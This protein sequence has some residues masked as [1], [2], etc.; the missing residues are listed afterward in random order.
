MYKIIGSSKIKI[1]TAISFLLSL[2]IKIAG[3]VKKDMHKILNAYVPINDVT[4]IIS[5]LLEKLYAIRFH[6]NPVKTVPLKNSITPNKRENKNK[7][8]AGFLIL[9]KKKQY[10]AKP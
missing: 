3:L 8:L 6:G 7:L 1:H 4:C 5:R 9:I 10:T 2:K